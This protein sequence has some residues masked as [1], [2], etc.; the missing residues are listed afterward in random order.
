LIVL[1]RR[2]VEQV[3]GV[4]ATD[5]GLV[6]KDWHVVH[7]LVVIAAVVSRVPRQVRG[8]IANENCLTS[9]LLSIMPFREC[10][11]FQHTPY[12]DSDRKSAYLETECGIL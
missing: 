9:S 11:Y 8:P 7:A 10:L 6:E 2:L 3:A 12:C 5:E 4:L 1:D